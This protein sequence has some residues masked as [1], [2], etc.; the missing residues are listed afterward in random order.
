MIEPGRS[1]VGRGRTAHARA[2]PQEESAKEFVIV[3]AAMNDLIRLF[4]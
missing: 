4:I 3:D 2:L 1:I